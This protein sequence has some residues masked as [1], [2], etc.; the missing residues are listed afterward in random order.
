MPYTGCGD[1]CQV[2][3]LTDGEP[4]KEVCSLRPTLRAVHIYDSCV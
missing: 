3:I 4:R 1:S 2:Y